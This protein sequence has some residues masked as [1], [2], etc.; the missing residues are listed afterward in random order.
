MA[1][2]GKSLVSEFMHL[3]P[4]VPEPIFYERIFRGTRAFFLPINAHLPKVFYGEKASLINSTNDISSAFCGE[5]TL[6]MAKKV[7]RNFDKNLPYFWRRLL[8]LILHNCPAQKSRDK[9]GKLLN[10]ILFTS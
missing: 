1:E 9:T 6:L 5:T 7:T 8:L 4:V 10:E 3:R 2:N